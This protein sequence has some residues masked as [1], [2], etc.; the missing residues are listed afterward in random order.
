MKSRIIIN[1]K[2]R[3]SLFDPIFNFLDFLHEDLLFFVV[4]LEGFSHSVNRSLQVSETF[5]K[6]FK[7]SLTNCLI[8]SIKQLF[9]S[10]YDF[11]NIFIRKHNFVINPSASLPTQGSEQ[12][13]AGR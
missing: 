10:I 1:A 3:R 6:F 8:F 11:L 12:V 2:F 4:L 13:G 5:L 7:I 9:I